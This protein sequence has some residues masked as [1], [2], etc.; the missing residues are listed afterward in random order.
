M[1]VKLNFFKIVFTKDKITEDD[2]YGS[3]GTCQNELFFKYT[4]K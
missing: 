1:I 3:C 4:S 2:L